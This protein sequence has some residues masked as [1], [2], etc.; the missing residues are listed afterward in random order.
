MYNNFKIAGLKFK[1]RKNL[2][3]SFLSD[4]APEYICFYSYMP[5]N[6]LP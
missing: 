6:K 1:V 4:S 3:W 2:I 5:F